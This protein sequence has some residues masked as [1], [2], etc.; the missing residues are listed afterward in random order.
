MFQ[1]SGAS[2]DFIFAKTGS[3]CKLLVKTIIVC[4]SRLN[5]LK[6]FNFVIFRLFCNLQQSNLIS[7]LSC[8]IAMHS[9]HIPYK[10]DQFDLSRHLVL[11]CSN[12]TVAV[13]AQMK[14]E[15]FPPVISGTT[16]L[17]C[18]GHLD[19]SLANTKI[20]SFTSKLKKIRSN[21]PIKIK[22]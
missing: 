12:M 17:D 3:Y 22:D 15:V 1:T 7:R 13:V 4:I 18:P 14:T 2:C 16:G 19:R 6:P 10:M 21:H 11:R 9:Q 20:I 8:N 5:C